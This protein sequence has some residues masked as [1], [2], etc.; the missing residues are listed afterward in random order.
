MSKYT[1]GQ[2]REKLKQ[3]PFP[4]T[5]LD[6][7]IKSK[8]SFGMSIAKNIY[9]KG[10]VED[11][12]SNRRIIAQENRDY[13]ANRQDINKY[14]PL[15]D[16]QIDND[17][18]ESYMNISWD[19]Q[20]PGK[21]FVDTIVGDMMNQDHKIQ[22]NAIDNY[23]KKQ[24]TKAR[25]D[26]YGA[27]VRRRHLEEIEQMSGLVLEKRGG[28]N[29][30]S[31]EEVDVY[32]EMEFKQAVEIGME[33]IVDYILYDNEWETKV[34][35]RV[36]RDFVENNKGAV[37]LFFDKNNKVCLRYV[38]APLNYYA[39]ATDE[40]DHSDTEY[41]A[42]KVLMSIGD[43]RKR[44]IKGEVTEKQWFEIAKSC[45]NKYGN[46]SWRFGNSYSSTNEYGG[47]PYSYSDY[48]VEV[49]DFVFYTTD[50]RTYTEQDDK[51]GNRHISRRDYGYKKPKKS[52]KNIEVINKEIEMSYEGL[53][54]PNSEILLGYGRTKNILRP[55]G[56]DGKSVSPKLIRRYVYFEPN[57]RNGSS[58]SF[59]RTI[60][61][62][63]DTIQLLVLR[64][65]HIIAEMNPTGVAVDVSGIADVM[66]A[67]EEED[68]MK[69]VKLY[70]QKGILFYSRTDVNGDPVNG[71]PIHELGNPFAQALIGIDNAI[72]NEI[73]SIRSNGGINDARD[74][75]SPDKDALV[76]IEKMR[77]LA[78]NNTTREIYKAF[79]D[80]IFAKAG[81]CAAR[82]VQCKVEYNNGIS[83]YDNII[84][85]QGVKSIEFAKSITMAQLGV[86]VEA[87]PTDD[88]IESLLKVLD[89]SLANKEIRVED[90]LEIKRISNVKKAERLLIYR[91]KVYAAEKM[92]E[93]KQ[94]EE[95]TA[96][97]EK[98]SA[99]AA[100]E[101]QVVKDESKA[102]SQM[103]ID[104]NKNKNEMEKIAF[105]TNED[106]KIIDREAYWKEELL[107][108]QINSD[109]P[110]RSGISMPKVQQNPGG[111]IERHA[112]V[113]EDV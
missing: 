23:S 103:Q 20:T 31:K 21:K 85:E 96:E 56:K 107:E 108:K 70:K 29:P 9:Y 50:D 99:M 48:R 49:L 51:F 53:W 43:L 101:A 58:T 102:K 18:D 55:M 33:S 12:S 7:K 47:N 59:V 32:M 44:D 61:P 91:K 81:K 80:G 17:G 24:I 82:M 15:L 5:T 2:L 4:V 111:A 76:G 93:F 62:N 57:L 95:I 104:D 45:S 64:K 39:S 40:S 27:I 65:R 8:K 63:L 89:M 1:E 41:Q 71:T 67:L 28:F 88:Q 35:K 110:V 84:G 25:D 98:S 68:P 86:K 66:A 77:L 10:L 78:S 94:K 105:Q 113:K 13:A 109:A 112:S 97:R 100:A 3:N 54:L 90:H 46:A 22:F 75:S 6:P 72:I 87:L 73:E 79:T 92:E 52:K 37:R 69:I 16:A 26:Y 34:S 42:E 14:K 30:S 11:H 106:L 19:I 60:M 38:D 74:G 36:I 83:E